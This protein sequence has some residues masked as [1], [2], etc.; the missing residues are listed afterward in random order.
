MTRRAAALVALAASLLLVACGASAHMAAPPGPAPTA[1]TGSGAPAVGRAAP[2]FQLQSVDGRT[3]SLAALRG[4]V[5]LVNFWATWCVPCTRELP[6]IDTVARRYANQGFSAAG[7]DFREQNDDVAAY[8]SKVKV[9]VPLLEDSTGAT[10]ERYKL[11]GVPTSYLIDRDGVIRAI[12]PG[13][14]TTGELDKAVQAVL[15]R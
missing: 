4:R 9:S 5:V 1:A 7:I 3:V 15:A 10:A 11:L 14:Y 13:P 2:D 6:A 8:A 12:H